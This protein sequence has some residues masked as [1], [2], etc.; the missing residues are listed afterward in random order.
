MLFPSD[1]FSI[2]ILKLTLIHCRILELSFLALSI[3]SAIAKTL[4]LKL[5]VKASM[6]QSHKAD[7]SERCGIS[8][9]LPMDITEKESLMIP[10][11]YTTGG[12]SP[13]K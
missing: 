7:S 9:F 5:D 8:T 1:L 10:D 4:L 11:S 12:S 2:L 3:K 13:P 6:M